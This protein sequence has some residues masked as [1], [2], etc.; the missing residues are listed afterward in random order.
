[1]NRTGAKTQCRRFKTPNC[2]VGFVII[3][4]EVSLFPFIFTTAR[5]SQSIHC[6]R[7]SAIMLQISHQREAFMSPYISLTLQS[8]YLHAC[9][10]KAALHRYV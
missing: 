9:L 5:R 8:Y 4:P 1:M 10:P 3:G 7:F 6:P 2:R